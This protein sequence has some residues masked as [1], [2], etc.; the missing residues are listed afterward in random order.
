MST[1]WGTSQGHLLSGL[2]VHQMDG[3]CSAWQ[4]RKHRGGLEGA[5]HLPCRTGIWLRL[6]RQGLAAPER[7][8][9]SRWRRG[10]EGPLGV[11]LSEFGI[12]ALCYLL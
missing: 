12:L 2:S 8:G 3:Y 6:Q 10:K 11:R 5:R 9:P 1:S 7:S 4:R